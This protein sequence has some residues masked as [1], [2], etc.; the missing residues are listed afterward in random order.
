MIYI[1]PKQ[2]VRFHTFLK[3]NQQKVIEKNHSENEPTELKRTLK[4]PNTEIFWHKNTIKGTH[5]RNTSPIP[6]MHML[7]CICGLASVQ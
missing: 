2:F 6:N 1:C 7:L 3:K 4:C 5:N